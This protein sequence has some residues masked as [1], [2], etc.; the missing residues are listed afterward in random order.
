MS[1]SLIAHNPSLS[2]SL[3]PQDGGEGGGCAEE[4]LLG[5]LKQDNLC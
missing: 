1:G 3:S 4:V 2:L 5:R